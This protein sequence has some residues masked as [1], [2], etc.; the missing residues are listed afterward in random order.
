MCYNLRDPIGNKRHM[1]LSWVIP[2]NMLCTLS[3]IFKGKI[4]KSFNICDNYYIVFIYTVPTVIF[5]MYF[6]QLH[7][8][9]C[10]HLWYSCCHPLYTSST[11]DM[12][13]IT[14]CDAHLYNITI[15]ICKCVYTMTVPCNHIIAWI[16]NNNNN[17]T[18][19]LIKNFIR[20]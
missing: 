9:I 1:L 5:L 10:F 4:P 3:V 18:C 19:I 16:N 14:I 12:H 13:F 8:K 15:Y 20:G 2:G 7:L 6:H 17:N 11:C